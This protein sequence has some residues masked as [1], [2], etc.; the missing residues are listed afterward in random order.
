MCHPDSAHTPPQSTMYGLII[1]NIVTYI[2]DN[3]GE[4]AWTEVKVRGASTLFERIDAC[5]SV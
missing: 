3:F 5:Q 4:D 1:D 2:R